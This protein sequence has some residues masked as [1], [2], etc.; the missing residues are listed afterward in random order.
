MSSTVNTH[1]N[2]RAHKRYACMWRETCRCQR[3]SIIQ[4]AHSHICYQNEVIFQFYCHSQELWNVY[5]YI[6]QSNI[7]DYL[8]T[9]SRSNR[10]CPY[11]DEKQMGW[12]IHSQHKSNRNSIR[13]V[14]RKCT[15]I[16]W[17]K[18]MLLQLRRLVNA[19]K[20]SQRIILLSIFG[21]KRVMKKN[22][23]K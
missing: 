11:R 12:N 15:Q 16:G 18:F 3:Q 6:A 21:V 5:L 8:G 1:T 23:N 13:F 7:F 14:C 20:Q 22:H 2:A 19:V 17:F 4:I 9:F 10:H